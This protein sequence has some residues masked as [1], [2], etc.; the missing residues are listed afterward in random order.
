MGPPAAAA[1]INL[2]CAEKRAAGFF[3]FGTDIHVQE[4]GRLRSK[5]GRKQERKKVVF[6]LLMLDD[7]LDI[8]LS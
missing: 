8:F 5:G 4:E 3:L 2:P 1:S 7:S 6:W